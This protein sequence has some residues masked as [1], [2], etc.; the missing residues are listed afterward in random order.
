MPMCA[1]SQADKTQ[2]EW[3]ESGKTF[4]TNIGRLKENYQPY[5]P[6]YQFVWLNNISWPHYF[7][8]TR[9]APFSKTLNHN[10]IEIFT[11]TD[12]WIR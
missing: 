4:K 2:P 5:V 11:H 9:R 12:K 1:W 10:Q 3:F 6:F 8:H 7:H